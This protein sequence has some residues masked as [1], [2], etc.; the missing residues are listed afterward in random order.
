MIA[1]A[2]SEPQP[3]ACPELRP[4][5]MRDIIEQVAREH[6]LT[7]NQMLARRR[8]R[9]LVYARQHAM[10]RCSKETRHSLPEIGRY[11]GDYDHTTVL[12]GIRSHE[13]RLGAQNE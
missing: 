3:A 5:N 11:F 6:G 2:W 13:K 8:D 7:V 12:H 1:V 10:W 9:H 4:L